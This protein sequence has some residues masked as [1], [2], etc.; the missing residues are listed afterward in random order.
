VSLIERTQTELQQPPHTELHTLAEE[1]VTAVVV[2]VSSSSSIFL[3]LQRFVSWNLHFFQLKLVFR[4]SSFPLVFFGQFLL[5][6]EQ[7]F[8]IF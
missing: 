7:T 4:F 8:I 6:F 1:I 3:D 2:D 5:S